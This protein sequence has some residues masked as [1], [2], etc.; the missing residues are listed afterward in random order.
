MSTFEYRPGLSHSFQVSAQAEIYNPITL[1]GS[2][3]IFLLF[4]KL[5]AK[6]AYFCAVNSRTVSFHVKGLVLRSLIYPTWQLFGPNLICCC[7]FWSRPY[8]EWFKS[9]SASP[10]SIMNLLHLYGILQWKD[11]CALIFCLQ[12]YAGEE[13]DVGVKSLSFSFFLSLYFI[14]DLF[15][16]L[17]L[18]I[19]LSLGGPSPSL[20]PAISS[21]LP[22][23]SGTSPSL[24]SQLDI[25]N[26]PRRINWWLLHPLICHNYFISDWSDCAI[27]QMACAAKLRFLQDQKESF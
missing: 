13:S 1:R 16:A 24:L 27:T 8:R 4:F 11:L 3:C 6:N 20:S 26:H 22:C 9:I 18:S 23:C 19:L 14:S 17:Y 25:W 2:R 7:W 12:S 21:I 15:P 5:D 10:E